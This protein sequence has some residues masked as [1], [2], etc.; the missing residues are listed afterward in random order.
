MWVSTWV[1]RSFSNRLTLVFFLT[2]FRFRDVPLPF[3]VF[4]PQPRSMA[5]AKS[6]IH[7][8]ESAGSDEGYQDKHCTS[9]IPPGLDD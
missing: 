6:L 8:S 4:P 9:F 3:L 1:Y 7:D 2:L 5:L